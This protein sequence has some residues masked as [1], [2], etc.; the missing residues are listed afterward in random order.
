M[1]KF[2]LKRSRE[3]FTLLELIVVL[4]ILALLAA[5]AIPTFNSVLIKTKDQRSIFELQGVS[6][7]AV[8]LS[9]FDGGTSQS[10]FLRTWLTSGKGSASASAGLYADGASALSSVA[11]KNNDNPLELGDSD[12]M[13][14]L[15]ELSDEYKFFSV[16]PPNPGEELISMA[17][18]SAHSDHCVF[19]T[20]NAS[21]GAAQGTA[22]KDWN[23]GSGTD[24]CRA[25]NAIS[26]VAGDEPTVVTLTAVEDQLT[27]AD[28]KSTRLNSSHWE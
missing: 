11:W 4:V 2:S 18:R 7:E 27:V 25:A 20:F 16:S 21:T 19:A 26:M 23:G 24:S 17:M 8:A 3:G 13:S 28:R 10:G 5:I 6:R 1:L 14:E 15:G 22:I 12:L 9:A